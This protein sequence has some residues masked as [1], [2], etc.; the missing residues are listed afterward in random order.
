MQRL[1]IGFILLGLSALNI[2]HSAQTPT[3]SSV[4]TGEETYQ[5]YCAGC[6]ETGTANAPRRSDTAFWKKRLQETG[7]RS[8]LTNVVISGKGAMPAKGGCAN[9]TEEEL[10]NSVAYLVSATSAATSAASTAL[11]I[12][13]LILPKG[14]QIKVL[15]DQ[16]PGARFLA[17]GDKGTLFVGSRGHGN[18]YAVTQ[19]KNGK[20]QKKTLLSGLDEPNGVAFYKG[21]LYVAEIGRITRYDNIEEKLD[22]PPAAVLITDKL[23]RMRWHGYKVINIGP[24]GLLYVAVGMPCNTCNYRDTNPV[25]G[26]IMRMKLDG[27]EIEPYAIGIRNSVGFDWHPTT[28]E[29]WFTDN[30]QDLMGDELPPD[31]INYAPKA[32]MDFGFPYVYGNNIP[33]PD[34]TKEKMDVSTFTVPAWELPAHVAPL[35]LTFYTGGQFPKAYQDQIFVAL[36]GSWNRSKKIGYQVVMLTLDKN[37]ITKMEP[38]VK[39]WLQG[40]NVWGRP[41]DMV[42]K[43]N[44]ALLI[45]DDLNGAIY[46]VTYAEPK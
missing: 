20:I 46:E 12:E 41:V 22:K 4:P 17:L 24:D 15:A 11:P 3:T 7:S 40:E 43:P 19:D 23:P 31:E 25:L 8:V 37:K 2:S 44:G 18:V 27:S 1:L 39:G 42:V 6:H 16:L 36:H 32:G 10:N 26:T 33:T 34:Y 9:C 29:M 14:F 5:H 30:G 21:A 13:K 35:G 28:K 45:S 38:F